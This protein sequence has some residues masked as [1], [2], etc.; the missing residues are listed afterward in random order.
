MWVH[1]RM[2]MEVMVLGCLV[3]LFQASQPAATIA[4]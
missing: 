1:S 2:A 3:S 4:S